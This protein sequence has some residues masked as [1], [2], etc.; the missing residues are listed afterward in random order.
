MRLIPI[1]LLYS[2][3]CLCASLQAKVTHI[4]I[5]STGLYQNGKKFDNIGTY[6]LLKGKAYFEIDPLAAINQTVVDVKLAPRDEKGMVHFSTDITLIIP[7]D[8]SKINGSLIYEFNN[9]GGML[10]P[11]VDAETNALFSRG[12]VFVSTGWIGELLPNPNKLRLYAPIAYGDNQ[13]TLTGNIRVE[14]IGQKGK[15]RLNVNG[16]GHG[17]YEPTGKGHKL[18]TLTKRMRV[19]D[20][21][22]VIPSDKFYIESSW[23]AYTCER[24]GL[25]EVELILTDSFEANY[26]YELIYEAKNPIVQGLGFV[27]IRDIISFLRYEKTGKN[28]LLDFN[29][30]PFIDRT[31]SFGISQSGRAIRM[32]LYEGFNEDE[33]GRKVFDGAVPMVAGAGMGFFNHRFA[34]PTRF[35]TQRE[36]HLFPADVFPFNYGESIDLF[37]P[38]KDGILKRAI[39][40]KV[41]PKIIHIQSSAEYWH[42]CA[43]LSHINVN[44]ST[45]ATLPENVRIYSIIGQHGSGTGTPSTK[46]AGTIAINH[47]N[48]APFVR[49]LIIALDD[50]IKTDKTPPP[51]VYPNFKDGTLVH[52]EAATVGWKSIPTIS[53]PKVIQ[54]AYTADFG[55]NLSTTKFI[56]QH[57]KKKKKKYPIYSPKLDAD[58]N[59]LGMLKVP[60]VAVPTGTYTGWNLRTPKMGAGGELLRLTGGYIP[61]PKTKKERLKSKDPRKSIEARYAN[62][63]VYYSAYKKVTA[64]LVQQGYLLEEEGKEILELAVKNRGL[65]E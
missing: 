16:G 49:S 9:R 64:E 28:P 52:W 51:S 30:Q 20:P 57:P 60:A 37:S 43:A 45:D 47:A 48:Y 8:K 50:W 27:G 12:F 62:F 4:D 31:I 2:F 14:I 13:T 15:N 39:A 44:T 63:E 26:I 1:F 17:A 7:T 3:V 41:V 40:K 33:Q 34:S 65:I 19:S 58:N 46:K 54:Q 35:S 10:L 36:S 11:Y 5:Q 59:E 53:Y 29:N 61:F 55:A 22:Q 23:S 21:R 32:F 24:D 18:A 42:R 25:P 38:K 56:T 6:D